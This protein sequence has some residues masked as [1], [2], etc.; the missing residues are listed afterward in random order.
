MRSFPTWFVN[1]LKKAYPNW[2]EIIEANNQ[3]PPMWLRVNQQQNGTKTYRTLLEEQE[4]ESFE[5]DNP[6]ALRLATHFLSRN[7][8]ILNRVQ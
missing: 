3:K 6:H 5:C 4:I 7:Y 1:K 8:Q 2:R